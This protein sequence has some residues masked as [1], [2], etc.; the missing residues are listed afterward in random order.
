MVAV[1]AAAYPACSS[2]LFWLIE[3]ALYGQ[4]DVREH[5]DDWT[6]AGGTEPTSRRPAAGVP[7]L[8]GRDGV[9]HLSSIPQTR[10][11]GALAGALKRWAA[12]C[13]VGARSLPLSVATRPAGSG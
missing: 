2:F 1:W 12:T 9:V 5:P 6:K 11:H 7:V 8:A 10:P 13:G 4:G 3:D